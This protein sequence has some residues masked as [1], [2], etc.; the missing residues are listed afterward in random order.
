MILLLVLDLTFLDKF[1]ATAGGTSNP[2]HSYRC[3]A[4]KRQIL[5]AFLQ[6]LPG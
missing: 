4:D 1:A 3:N 6:P 5:P 2:P